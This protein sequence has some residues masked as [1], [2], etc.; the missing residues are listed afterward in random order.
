MIYS[1]GAQVLEDFTSSG[2]KKRLLS[3]GH[4]QTVKNVLINDNDDDDDGDDNNN[5]YNN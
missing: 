2:N 4:K 5:S 1:D 3:V